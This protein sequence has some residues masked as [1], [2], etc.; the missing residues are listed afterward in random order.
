[1]DGLFKTTA[2]VTV[3]S[4]AEK[5]L[6]FLYR[7]YLSRTIGSEGLGL[8]Q[9]ALSVFALLM[10]LSCSGIPATVS[11]LITKYRSEGKKNRI[12]GVSTAGFL[13]S[14]VFTVPVT[15][16]VLFFP[17]LF[18]FLFA[19]ERC[20]PLFRLIIPV[21]AL[22]SLY[23]VLRGIFWGNNDFLPY[24]VIELIE[25]AVMIAVGVALIFTASDPFTGAKYAIIAVGASY[26][27]SFSLGTTFYVYRKGKIKS[28][29]RELK[30][31]FKS[32]LPVTA[33][34][35]AGS[36]VSSLV[37]VVFPL[38]LIAAG[39]GKAE[40]TAAYGAF[41]GM[42]MPLLSA[43][44]SIIGPFTIVLI[45]KIAESFYKKDEAALKNDIEKALS[46]TVFL[47]SLCV[48]VFL[49]FGEEIGLFV[50]GSQGG[51]LF[52]SRAA[53]L[54]V[55]LC[56]NSLTTSMLNSVG[57]ELSTFFS[58]AISTALML[59][60]IWFL[61]AVMGANSLVLCYVLVFGTNTAVNLFLIG[62][63]TGVKLRFGGFAFYSL[64]F[65]I[66]T[67]ALGFLLKS[68]LI[69][70][71]GGLLTAILCSC[72]LVVFDGLFFIVFGLV[73]IKEFFAIIKGKLF[74]R[75]NKKIKARVIEKRK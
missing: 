65:L 61:P 73:D 29:R 3:F 35:S 64:I 15:I 38:R 22:N 58:F 16:I 8:Y 24:S 60:S 70:Y 39:F 21:L 4:L 37:S 62:K 69:K 20:L 57:E 1:M 59:V 13:S 27:V 72:L 10:T 14:L 25:E 28:P 63:K 54:T 75:K 7:I 11:R 26:I 40:A 6:G 30:P 74:K 49:C 46:V 67:S 53:I 56:V 5:F 68:L 41:F 47:S 55:L 33:V 19:D 23:S 42:A 2:V 71:L 36:L 12:D 52:T 48:P 9:I 43:P 50:F 66:P 18:G 51:G 32:S 44:M 17:S 34:R 45:P 31:L